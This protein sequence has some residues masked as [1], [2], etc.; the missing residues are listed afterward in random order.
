MKQIVF[1]PEWIDDFLKKKS[2]EYYSS[3]INLRPP[4]HDLDREDS[5]IILRILRNSHDLDGVFR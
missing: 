3:I 1:Y 5:S 2:G 4:K